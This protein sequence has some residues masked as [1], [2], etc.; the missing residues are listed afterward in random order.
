[1]CF[2]FVTKKQSICNIMKHLAK[3]LQERKTGIWCA[4]KLFPV[5][6]P[7]AVLFHVI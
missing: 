7:G 4:I 6:V 5:P 1:M 3:H 2:F